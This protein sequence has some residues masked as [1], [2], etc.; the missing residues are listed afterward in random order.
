MWSN[1]GYLGLSVLTFIY[2]AA[3]KILVNLTWH[4]AVGENDLPCSSLGIFAFCWFHS[5][6]AE[7][8]MLSDAEIPIWC[9]TVGLSQ[10]SGL[11]KMTRRWNITEKTPAR[12][13]IFN[14]RRI[15]SCYSGCERPT[16]TG[17]Y[18]CMKS[19]FV[20]IKRPSVERIILFLQ[21]GWFLQQMKNET[22]WKPNGF[23]INH[24]S[25]VLV[26]DCAHTASV[27]AGT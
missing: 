11:C 2:R 26:N 8:K 24:R 5:R 21:L 7:S 9:Y 18:V 4:F 17:L 1:C 3:N 14:Q 27:A 6:P 19:C 20:K 13:V 22:L 25:S 16:W 15:G 12:S 10:A 23:N